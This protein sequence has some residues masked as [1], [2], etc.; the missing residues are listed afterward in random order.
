MIIEKQARDTLT[1]FELDID[2]ELHF[3]LKSGQTRRIQL[4]HCYA[5]VE[6]TTLKEPGKPE[7]GGMT[8]YRFHCTL[9]IDGIS[10][11][12][13]R[14]VGSQ[15]SFYQPW[16]IMGLRIWFD[17][18]TDIFEFMREQH[19]PCKPRKRARFAVQDATDRICPTLLHPW[20]PLPPQTLRIEQCYRGDDCWLGAY[21][22]ADAHGGLDINHRAGTPLWTPVS[23]D[24]HFFFNALA[25]GDNNNRWRGFKRWQDGSTWILQSHHLI[26]LLVPEHEPIQAGTNYAESAGVWTG[27]HEHTHFVFKVIEPGQ[28]EED[29]IALDPWI[30]F[31]QMYRDRE[32][33]NA[34]E[35]GRMRSL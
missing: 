27:N 15:D 24:D 18:C 26:R 28:S 34:P 12:M 1:A 23:I 5:K 3:T 4:V 13:G 29:A 11:S 9:L 16:E 22:G 20:C 19:G 32:L 6:S 7:P 14:Y 21:D 35:P 8:R 33:T 17:A 2:D 25:N 10:V 31:W 30:L